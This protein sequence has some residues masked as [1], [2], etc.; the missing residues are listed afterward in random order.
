MAVQC[1]DQQMAAWLPLYILV[2]E[3]NIVNRK[4]ALY[5]LAQMGYRAE[6]AANGLEVLQAVQRRRYDIVLMDVHMPEMDGFE[7]TRRIHQQLPAG[8]RPRIIAMTADTTHADHAQCLAVGMDD[9]IS[10]PVQVTELQAVLQRWGHA[11][12]AP[13]EREGGTALPEEEFAL[14]T[15]LR[16][17]QPRGGRDNVTKLIDLFL[18]DTPPW[19]TALHEALMRSDAR[20]FAHAAHSLKGSCA[21]IG[22][23]RMAALCAALEQRAHQDHLEAMEASLDGLAAEFQRVRQVLEG[24]RQRP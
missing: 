19:L 2:A 11:T 12:T 4:V 9:Y 16:A 7:A 24:K 8:Q 23:K 14:L 21:T 17:M 6:I 22:A 15:T 1:L 18:E 3:D 20:A 5:L 13:L 10:K